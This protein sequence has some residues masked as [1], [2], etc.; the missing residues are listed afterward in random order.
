MKIYF[1]IACLLLSGLAVAQTSSV[2]AN[3]GQATKDDV[4]RLMTVLD[5]RGQTQAVL[6]SMMGPM[7]SGE[8]DILKQ[9]LEKKGKTLTPQQE[10]AAREFIDSTFDEVFKVFNVDEM[11][12]MMIPI[13]QK[14]FTSDDINAMAAFYSSPTGRKVLQEMP[15]LMQEVM[16]SSMEMMKTKMP[17]ISQKIDAKREAF[18][19]QMVDSDPE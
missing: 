18:L 14:H 13:Y 11:M 6:A 10:K 7:K 16:Q 19:K 9:E 12:Q 8:F 15:G 3:Q 5:T 2:A 4:V 1:A 17:A